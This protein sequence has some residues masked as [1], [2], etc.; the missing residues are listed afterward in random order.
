MEAGQLPLAKQPAHCI[1]RL[2]IVVSFLG[3]LKTPARALCYHGQT[4]RTT[5]NMLCLSKWNFQQTV[6]LVD[7]CQQR[8][9]SVYPDSRCNESKGASLPRH[10]AGASS[11][12]NGRKSREGG[13]EGSRPTRGRDF[14]LPSPVPCYPRGW[15]PTFTL[16]CERRWCSLALRR[17]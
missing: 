3:A 10:V 16:G 13:S 14:N 12:K 8:R 17:C 4:L 7:R 5:K 6:G 9:I 2:G 15:D 1:F 11:R